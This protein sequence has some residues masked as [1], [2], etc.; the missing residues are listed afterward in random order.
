VFLFGAHVSAAWQ[1]D[2]ES[3]QLPLAS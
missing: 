1:K 2:G 3:A